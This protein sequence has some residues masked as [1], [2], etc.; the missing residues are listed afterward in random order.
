MARSQKQPE[1]KEAKLTFEQ[2]KAAIPKIDRRISDLKAFDVSQITDPFDRRV[3]TL[4]TSLEE[5]LASVFGTGTVQY[6]RY[7]FGV[8]DINPESAMAIMRDPHPQEVQNS[9][10]KGI[11]GSIHHLEGIKKLFLEELSD[12]VESS[13]VKNEADGV[14]PALTSRKV[15][16]VHGHNDGIKESVARFLEKLDL[17]LIVLHEQPNKGRTIIEKFTDYS[18]VGFAVILMTAD[19][20]GGSVGSKYEDLLP[21]A[22]Q[23]VILELGY[24]LG[25]IGRQKVCA[26]YSEGVEIPT[27][28][29]G[30]LFVKLEE[31][32][33][34]RLQ[35]AKEI[36]AAGIDVDMNRAF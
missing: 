28:Y 13:A 36:K 16:L 9:L 32:G 25:K 31:T 23:N 6:N 24:F 21:R 27:D 20:I 5:L 12:A 4:Q 35:I 10:R 2:K 7:H 30:V 19:D 34:W 17:A 26:L 18:D 1:P 8:T 15:F 3:S 14:F 22:R 29:Q 11:Q 33:M